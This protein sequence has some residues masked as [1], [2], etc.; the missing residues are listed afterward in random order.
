MLFSPSSGASVHGALVQRSRVVVIATSF[1]AMA[2]QLPLRHATS[3]HYFRDA[4][5]LLLSPPAGVTGGG[6]DLF[7]H[8]PQFQF[9][10][11]AVLLAAPFAFLPANVGVVSIM[12]VG[13]VLGLCTL[14][15]VADANRVQLGPAGASRERA[16][17]IA[18]V[19]FVLVWG[20][21]ALRTAHLDDA[22]ALTA[23]A[24]AVA[25]TTRSRSG[26]AT[27]ALAIAAAAK[28]WAI[29]FA[30]I[31]LVCPGP[32]KSLRLGTIAAIVTVTWLPFVVD[33]PATVR[34]AGTFRIQNAAA[35]ALRVLGDHTA[36]TPSWVRPTQMIG[37]FALAVVLVAT[38]RWRHVVM[39]TLALRL[40]LDPAV[41]HY[42]AAGLALGV[43]LWELD[44]RRGRTPVVTLTTALVLEVTSSIAQPAMAAG[45]VRLALTGSLL[46]LAF[47][48]P[49]D[50]ASHRL[51]RPFRGQPAS[52]RRAVDLVSSHRFWLR[53][54]AFSVGPP[55]L[56]VRPT[57]SVRRARGRMPLPG[58]DPDGVAHESDRPTRS[59]GAHR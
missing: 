11:I 8:N 6:L 52:C 50:G 47:L 18:A 13:S 44:R 55:D 2:A 14:A 1:G 48:P 49:F 32:R 10:P 45:I 35:S 20:D 56:L 17:I 54:T 25:A 29:V 40:M 42:Y 58:T 12:I 28:P 23:T 9:G 22:L 34:A 46:V 21:I 31:A 37:G 57:A 26:V 5:H 15:A 53:A 36:L 27:F 7:A 16:A 41:H 3:W 38:S 4:A 30:P 59:L 24:I 43:L 19:P 33:E 51:Q 39:A